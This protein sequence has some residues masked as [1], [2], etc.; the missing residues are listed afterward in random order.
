[1][2]LMNNLPL[3]GLGGLGFGDQSDRRAISKSIGGLSFW[4]L[5][6]FMMQVRQPASAVHHGS[7]FGVSFQMSCERNVKYKTCWCAAKNH[8]GLANTEVW[9]RVAS[10]F[11]ALSLLSRLCG[12]CKGCIASGFGPNP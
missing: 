2:G 8:F 7:L 11:V 10:H 4:V 5:L 6:E 9:L 12:R 3:N 1:M